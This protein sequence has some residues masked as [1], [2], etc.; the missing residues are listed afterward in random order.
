MKKKLFIFLFLSLSVLV[1]VYSAPSFYLDASY[2]YR[3]DTNIYSDPLVKHASPDWLEWRVSNPYEKRFSNGFYTS[4]NILFSD[5][6]RTGL[7]TSLDASWAYKDIRYI[8]EGYFWGDWEYVEYD[9]TSDVYASMFC[10]IGPVFFVDFGIVDLGISTKLSIGTFDF[11]PGELV[12]GLMVDPFINV[13]LTDNLYLTSGMHY[14][15]HLM[16]F[17]LNN[18]DMIYR[19]DYSMVT[20]GGYLGV[21]VYLDGGG[22]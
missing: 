18:P 10:G 11:K 2:L 17:Y 19:K 1:F 14:D 13:F 16:S 4:L 8:P 7:S 20:V 15:A 6:D 3:Y 22:K 12:L 5:E 9:A 21:G